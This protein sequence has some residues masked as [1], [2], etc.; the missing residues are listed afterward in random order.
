M[1]AAE[2]RM[3]HMKL[4]APFH[5]PIK[6]K[7]NY[8]GPSV[9]SVITGLS[10]ECA[11][12]WIRDVAKK[13]SV[14]GVHTHDL[15]ST[16]RRRGVSL[17]TT[18]Y[19]TER[20]TLNQWGK[21]KKEHGKTYLLVAGN[22]FVVVRGRKIF[23]NHEGE[24]SLTQSKHKRKRVT[25][26]IEVHSRLRFTRDLWPDGKTDEQLREEKRQQMKRSSQFTELLKKTG[27]KIEGGR[28]EDGRE[29]EFGKNL[30]YD[31]CHYYTAYSASIGAEVLAALETCP[32]DCDCREE[33]RYNGNIDGQI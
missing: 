8:C 29:I 17:S 19:P 33:D 31:G 21:K 23:D 1:G 4:T 18:R 6:S 14:K 2:L 3:T 13:R 20:L 12:A 30:S 32:D 7:N 27:S 24:Q 11:A 15:K 10:C 25:E 16:L 22:H 9:I 28:W 5:N 26:V